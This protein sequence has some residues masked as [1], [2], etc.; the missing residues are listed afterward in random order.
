[1]SAS[2]DLVVRGGQVCTP[3]GLHQ[4]DVAIAKGRIVALLPP[5]E[6][7][8]VDRVI[9]AD[10]LTVLPGAIDAHVHFDD[11]GRSDWEGWST[12][13]LAAAAGGVTTVI[14]MPIDSDPPTTSAQALRDKQQAATGT[15]FVD[16]ALWGG[17]IDADAERLSDLASAGAAGFKAFLCDCGWQDFP[18]VDDETLEQACLIAAKLDLVVGVH[19]ET[20]ALLLSTGSLNSRRPVASEIDAVARVAAVARRTGA[21]VHIVHCSSAGAVEIARTVPKMTVE[22]CPHYLALSSDDVDRIGTLAECAPPVRDEPN[23]LQLWEAVGCRD[24]TTIASDHS[25]CLPQSK[26]TDPPFLGIDGVETTLSVLLSEERCDITRIS[27]LR[28]AAAAIFG[29]RGKGEL[30]TGFDADLALVDLAATWTVGT[31]TVHSRHRA[32]PYAGRQLRG[33]VV[34][35]IVGGEIVYTDDASVGEPRGRF[36]RPV[37]FAGDLANV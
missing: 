2:I 11:P 9:S 4:L 20:S 31:D 36:V 24:I 22:T 30:A 6:I 15:S 1:M 35:T 14:D 13:S 33:K 5:G 34:T 32:S 12:G 3:T 7:T 25:P 16:F 26:Q 10:G 23:R 28:T 37:N 19:C 29:L 18:P 27:E 8:S 21:R 17:L